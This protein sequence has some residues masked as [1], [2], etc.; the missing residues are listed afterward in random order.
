M[1]FH[2]TYWFISESSNY[3]FQ[4][5]SE[6]NMEKRKRSCYETSE[7]H[8]E[9]ISCRSTSFEQPLGKENL[10]RAALQKKS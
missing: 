1:T 3:Y 8:E 10:W 4:S 6:K 7:S 9:D 2:D 5:C